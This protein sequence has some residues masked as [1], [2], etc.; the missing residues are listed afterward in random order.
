[1]KISKEHYEHIKQAF[2]TLSVNDNEKHWKHLKQAKKDRTQYIKDID[3]RFRWDCF[4]SRNLSEW[5][6]TT[7]YPIGI[8]DD[9]IDTALKNIIKELGFPSTTRK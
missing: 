2:Q 9:H 3:M 8:N 4:W 6:R 1:M 7:L 5:V